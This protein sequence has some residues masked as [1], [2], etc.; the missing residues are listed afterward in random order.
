MAF[1]HMIGRI[2]KPELHSTLDL[3]HTEHSKHC[4]LLYH[5]DKIYSDNLDELSLM[6]LSEQ[7]IGWTTWNAEPHKNSVLE[8][9][10]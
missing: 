10:P 3:L 9:S 5:E 4:K 7:I 2:W 8:L 6:S 1:G